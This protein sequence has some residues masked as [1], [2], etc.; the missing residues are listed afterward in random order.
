MRPAGIAM[1]LF[2]DGFQRQF[3]YLVI[4]VILVPV[5]ELWSSKRENREDEEWRSMMIPNFQFSFIILGWLGWVEYIYHE[6][7]SCELD[8]Y[9]YLPSIVSIFCKPT[10]LR[11]L[12]TNHR[13]LGWPSPKGMLTTKAPEP[14]SRSALVSS[15]LTGTYQFHGVSIFV[16][17]RMYLYIYICVCVYAYVYIT[18]TYVYIYNAI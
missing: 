2:G 8:I 4:L 16:M 6:P 14:K 7:W 13:S 11:L 9:I 5:A 18:H 17:L 10:N 15:D 12:V 1:I 3:S